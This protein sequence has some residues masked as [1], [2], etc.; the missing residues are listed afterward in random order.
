METSSEGDV[1]IFNLPGTSVDLTASR[2]GGFVGQRVIPVHPNA[3]T[4]STL[5]P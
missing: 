5:V 3:V 1:L 2:D 4:G